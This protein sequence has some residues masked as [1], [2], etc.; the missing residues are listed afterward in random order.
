MQKAITVSQQILFV[1]GFAAFIAAAVHA[2][3][4]QGQT[5]WRV[6]IAMM[7]T[8]ITLGQVFKPSKK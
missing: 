2:A 6:G 3:D 7:L 4:D 8:S 5:F 1:L